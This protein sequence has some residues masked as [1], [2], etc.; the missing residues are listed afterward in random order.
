MARSGTSAE[1]IKTLDRVALPVYLIDDQRRVRYLNAA[2]ARWLQVEVGDVI[3]MQGAYHSAPSEASANAVAEAAAQGL[4]PPPAAFTGQCV[5][6]HRTGPSGDDTA[7]FQFCALPMLDASGAITQVLALA[8][9]AEAQPVLAAD[10][11][12]T[13]EADRLHEALRIFFAS[14]QDEYRLERLVGTSPAIERA[15]AQAALAIQSHANVLVVGPVGSGRDWLARA[16]HQSCRSAAIPAVPLACGVLAEDLL[17]STLAAAI[18]A[19]PWRAEQHEPTGTLLLLDIDQLPRETFTEFA[20]LLA[21]RR[22]SLQVLATSR[23][24]SAELVQSVG[25]PTLEIYLPPLS[26]RLQDLPLLVQLLVEDWNARN[27]RQLAGAAPDTVDLLATYG[28][29][30]NWTELAE[31]ISQSCVVANGP[32]ILPSD[33]PREFQLALAAQARPKRQAETIKLPQFL[34]E[35]ERELITR[36]LAQTKGNKAKAARLLGISRP[37]LLRRLARLKLE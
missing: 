1:L 21:P 34:G 25:M 32:L 18:K 7:G 14:Q 17:T 2:C 27:D 10:L 9:S 13:A 28:W 37:T 22:T 31:V 20:R 35:V 19:H 29:P 6:Y 36:A 24:T 26:E 3:G 5:T 16:I 12:A 30:G 15:R 11:A 4:C 33:L 8:L 23:R